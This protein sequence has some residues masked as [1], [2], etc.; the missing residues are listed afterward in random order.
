MVINDQ[1]IKIKENEIMKSLKNLYNDHTIRVTN[2]KSN[3]QNPSS[4][5]R[6]TS[7]IALSPWAH[8]ITSDQPPQTS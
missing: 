3:N 2:Y 1:E 5:M 4:Q 7:K 8:L 6:S